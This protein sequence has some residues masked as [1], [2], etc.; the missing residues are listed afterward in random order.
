MSFKFGNNS[1]NCLVN[2]SLQINRACA[3]SNVLETDIDDGLC[4]NGCGGSTVTC[5]LI[6]LGSDF[7]NHLCTHIGESVLKFYLLSDSNTV[8]CDLRST[9]LLV[10]N[11]V[12][13]LRSECNLNSICKRVY[14]LFHFCADLNVEF[15]IFSHNSNLL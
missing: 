3:C 13:A 8:L 6:S 7:L 15:D 10:N 4:E 14:A 1:G 12:T 11:N 5:L 9:E 2:T